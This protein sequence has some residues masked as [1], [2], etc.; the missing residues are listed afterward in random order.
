MVLGLIR[1][2]LRYR[3]HDTKGIGCQEDHLGG[4]IPFGY[5]LHNIIDMI[6]GIGYPGVLSLGSVIIIDL[7]VS[8][9]GYIL[10]QVITL[11]RMID[12]RLTL[13]AQVDGLGITTPFEIEDALI[14]PSML[15]VPYQP[16]LR[17]GR[18]GGLTCSG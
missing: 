9:Y 12:V 14:V 16:A 6:N 8:G 4:M 2:Q 7:S 5:R 18:K 10:Q 15:I 17:I 3:W 1:G 11:H 13:F